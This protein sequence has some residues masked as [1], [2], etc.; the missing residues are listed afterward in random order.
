MATKR[1]TTA[2]AAKTRS[3]T[4]KG[5]G[6][7][8]APAASRKSGSPPQRDVGL[9]AAREVDVLE[10][11]EVHRAAAKAGPKR[12]AAAAK[13]QATKGTSKRRQAASAT[14]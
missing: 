9:E 10:H 7:T 6:G 4:T 8:R 14:L 13:A 5:A 2:K 1:T 11:A 3:A 12:T